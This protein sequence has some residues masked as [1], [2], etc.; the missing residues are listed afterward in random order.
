MQN[1]WLLSLCT[2]KYSADLMKICIYYLLEVVM[3]IKYDL[4]F[5]CTKCGVNTW[6]VDSFCVTFVANWKVCVWGGGAC[7]CHE[8]KS[9]LT[10][11]IKM[12]INKWYKLFSEGGCIFKS[13]GPSTQPV[14]EDWVQAA[15][16]SQSKKVSK[17]SYVIF[18]HV[19]SA[20]NC[21]NLF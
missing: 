4:S 17:T 1:G 14:I 20:Q 12:L 3:R 6:N 8:L 13:K 9:V 10:M 16:V 19:D 18:K 11:Q 21:V 2:Q 5:L 7:T 15:F